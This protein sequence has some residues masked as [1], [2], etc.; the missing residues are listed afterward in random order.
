MIT[1]LY[2]A[3]D[4]TDVLVGVSLDIRPGEHLAVVGASGAGKTTLGRLIAGIDRPRAG[5]VT[6][7]GA[8]DR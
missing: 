6:V 3:Y 2:Y 4:D 1:D 8:V 7:G 5:S